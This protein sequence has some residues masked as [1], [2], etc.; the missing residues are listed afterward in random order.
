MKIEVEFKIK[1][2]NSNE[3]DFLLNKQLMPLKIEK[4][5]FQKFNRDFGRYEKS[6]CI[7]KVNKK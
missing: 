7:F 5:K 1:H 4:L 2:K 6:L 3:Y